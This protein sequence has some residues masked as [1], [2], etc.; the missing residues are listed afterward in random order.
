MRR[1]SWVMWVCPES[2]VLRGLQ[3]PEPK[4]RR[5]KEQYCSPASQV[6][7]RPGAPDLQAFS[8]QNYERIKSCFFLSSPAP[9]VAICCRNHRKL[10][11]TPQRCRKRG[12]YQEASKDV[13]F[14]IPFNFSELRALSFFCRSFL[15]SVLEA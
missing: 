8:L 7:Y 9:I 13:I 3:V 10:I 2:N 14:Q 6:E 11:Y 5:G 4:A 1:S 15:P 12:L